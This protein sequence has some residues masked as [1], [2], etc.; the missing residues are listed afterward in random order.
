MTFPVAF[1]APFDVGGTGHRYWRWKWTDNQTS[2]A[3]VEFAELELLISG[4]DQ[5]SPSTTISQTGTVYN[6]VS[7]LVDN[8]ASTNWQ[9]DDEAMVTID[10]GSALAIT[11]YSVTAR[12]V[13]SSYTPKAWD[14]S[15]SDDG[16]SFTAV[17]SQSAQS[18]TNG[19][20]KTYA[21]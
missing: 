20:K 6:A 12:S 21:I 7:A 10:L 9:G 16:S 3:Y 2:G 11:H 13:G 14:F 1:G 19:E 18:F 8:N 4:T 5:T 17:H 15:Y